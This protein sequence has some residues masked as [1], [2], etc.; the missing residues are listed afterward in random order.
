MNISISI[1]IP[2]KNSS[3]TIKKCIESLLKQR[4]DNS[5]FEIICID[6][7]GLDGSRDVLQPFVSDGNIRLL[8]NPKKGVSAARNYGITQSKMDYITF[9]D[10]DDFV[11]DNYLS[12]FDSIIGSNHDMGITMITKSELQD[13]NVDNAIIDLDS[14]TA[15]YMLLRNDSFEGYAVNKLFNKKI[16]LNNQV[17]FNTEL[18]HYEDLLFC[19]EYLKYVNRIGFSQTKTYHYIDNPVSVMNSAKIGKNEF[20]F[21]KTGILSL[22]KIWLLN[23][24][25]KIKLA[26]ITRLVWENS[27]ISRQLYIESQNKVPHD[28]S[29]KLRCQSRDYIKGHLKV[30]LKNDIYGI[31]DKSIVLLDLLVPFLAYLLLK[32]KKGNFY[33]E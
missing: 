31:R 28:S 24:D 15:S 17:M 33:Y 27:M 5:L 6:D 26:L 29:I 10:S 22:N 21:S 16:L 25:E 14:K 3:H 13:E 32:L 7:H 30:F 23:K 4:Y 1:I 18:T 20:D 2:F 9:V 8:N 12:T 11:D 19:F